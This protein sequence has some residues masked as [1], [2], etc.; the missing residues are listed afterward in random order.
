LKLRLICHKW[1]YTAFRIFTDSMLAKHSQHKTACSANI[2]LSAN[3]GRELGCDDVAWIDLAEALVASPFE[4]P[5][6]CLVSIKGRK[7]LDLV[8][9][10]QLLKEVFV[11]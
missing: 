11:P 5:N 7:L 6:E 10:Y 2:K 4:H 3:G 9:S 8:R 1:D